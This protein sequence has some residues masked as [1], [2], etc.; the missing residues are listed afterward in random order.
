MTHISWYKQMDLA[1]P[2]LD[3]EHRAFMAVV[4]QAQE[5]AEKEDFMKFDELFESCYEYARTHFPHEE[6]LMERMG[7]PDLEAHAQSHQ[8]FIENISELRKAYSQAKT[9]EEYRYITKKTAHFL[10]SWFLGHL[11][12]RDRV[13]KPYL[14][15]LRNLPPRMDY[16]K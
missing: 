16:D 8:Q 14:V 15:R 11:L 6:D 12:G 4:N 10:S 13:Y 7:F 2:P 5:C 3:D 9:P 1:Y